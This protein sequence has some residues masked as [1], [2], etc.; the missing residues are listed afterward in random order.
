MLPTREHDVVIVGGGPAGSA[1]AATL[2]MRGRDVVVLERTAFPR[3]S[4]GESLLPYCWWTLQRIGALEAVSGAGFQAKHSVRFVTAA[5]ELSKPFTF[6]DHLKHE[7]AITWQVERATFDQILLDNARAQGAEVRLETRAT[8]L[9][10]ED[11]R[12]RGV[13]AVGPDGVESVVRARLTIDASGRDGFVRGLRRWR[14]P[15]PALQRLAYWTYYEGVE[16]EEGIHRGATTIV[17]LPED[18]WFWFIPQSG[19]KVSVGVVALPEVL[20]KHSRDPEV[21][22]AEQTA[23]NPWLVER[24]A[25]GTRCDKLRVT[26]DYSFRSE[27]CADDGLVLTGDAFA[28]LDPVFSSGVFLALRTGEE[29][30]LAADA[31]LE[32]GAVSASDFEAYGEWACS[33]IEAMRAL[34]FSFYDP[35]FSMGTLMRARPDLRGDVTDLLIGNLS[36]DF[37]A[38]YTALSEHGNC[39]PPLSYGRARA[40]VA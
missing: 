12:V 8:A 18:G 40:S 5:G 21:V 37:G 27:V 20:H 6:T 28:F 9:I 34:V 25:T 23:L 26:S 36:R 15:E 33:A 14:R 35:H 4:V 39:P 10:E 32:R 16:L 19:G 31:A 11:G 29:A 22:W 2:A 1:A 30:A 7:A 3:Y 38:L 17:Q 24:L 13:R